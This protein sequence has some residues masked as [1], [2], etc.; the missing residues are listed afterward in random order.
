[1]ANLNMYTFFTHLVLQNEI[2]YNICTIYETGT[3]SINPVSRE[4]KMV[5]G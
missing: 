3:E 5:H 1:M 2:L 4:Y